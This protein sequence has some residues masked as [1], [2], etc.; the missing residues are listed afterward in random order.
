MSNEEILQILD[1]IIQNKDRIIENIK[2]GKEFWLCLGNNKLRKK[3]ELIMVSIKK[4]KKEGI[5]YE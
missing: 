5:W 2:N 3:K 4:E 1:G